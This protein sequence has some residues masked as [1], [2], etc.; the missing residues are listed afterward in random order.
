[1]VQ[2]SAY[3][4]CF[5]FNCANSGAKEMKLLKYSIIRGE[6]SELGSARACEAGA[7][8]YGSKL[9]PHHNFSTLEF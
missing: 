9:K 7:I 5:L 1:M 4:L 8:L 6:M 2:I 3:F